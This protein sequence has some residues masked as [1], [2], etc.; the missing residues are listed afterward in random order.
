M[1]NRTFIPT[2]HRCCCA[3]CTLSRSAA[4]K[5]KETE[6]EKAPPAPSPI[7]TAHLSGHRAGTTDLR[8]GINCTMDTLDSQGQGEKKLCLFAMSLINNNLWF[9][10]SD[11]KFLFQNRVVF[12]LFSK[13]THKITAAWGDITSAAALT[14]TLLWRSILCQ[15]IALTLVFPHSVEHTANSRNMELSSHISE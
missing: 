4:K 7:R 9:A 5:Q 12:F 3:Q 11:S 6:K 8:K 1:T 14:N 10:G 2:V 15:G 13:L